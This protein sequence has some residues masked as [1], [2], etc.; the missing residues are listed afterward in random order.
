MLAGLLMGSGS[1]AFARSAA[2]I[3]PSHSNLAW[4]LVAFE[5]G[6]W[7]EYLI[8]ELTPDLEKLSGPASPRISWLML[9]E[10]ALLPDFAVGLMQSDRFVPG[11]SL[12]Q[13]NVALDLSG[14]SPVSGNGQRLERS[15]LMP[16]VSAS[17]ADRGVFTV[18]AVLATQR[19]VSAGMNLDERDE[20]FGAN[21]P[22]RGYYRSDEVA[23][24]AG[25]RF[26]LSGE[27]MERLSV[28]AAFQSRIDMNEF[29]SVRGVHGSRA[30]LDIPSRLQVGMELQTSARTS[31]NFGVSQI[32]YSEV[33]AF[34]SRSLPARF[35]ALLGDSTSPQFD[36]DDLLVYSLGWS[37][38]QDEVELFMDY[39]TRSQPRPSAPS[40]ASALA[41]ELAQN[42]FMVGVNKGFGDRSRLQVNAAYAPPEYA[43][44]GNVLGIVSDR[45]DQS[46]ELQATWRVD[47]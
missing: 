31:V 45:L 13:R 15:V 42:A 23:H 41:S 33:G 17:M 27:L 20:P 19:F 3:S 9:D 16:G 39:R 8:H 14:A 24:G 46:L 35:N 36:W 6:P 2:S 26:A 25:I 18:S 1:S 4:F 22:G 47:F 10:R 12:V 28:Q 38:Q 40:L 32:F 7:E 34:P 5:L 11:L 37:W 29:A 30:E 21:G 44:G 43:F